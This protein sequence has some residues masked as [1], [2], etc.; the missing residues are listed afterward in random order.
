MKQK[1]EKEVSEVQELPNWMVD[2][3]DNRVFVRLVLNSEKDN[4]KRDIDGFYYWFPEGNGAWATNALKVLTWY[5]DK[6]NEPYEQY[7]KEN[8]RG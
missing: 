2:T 7:V 5:I 1:E 3:F 8:L 4:I 6:L